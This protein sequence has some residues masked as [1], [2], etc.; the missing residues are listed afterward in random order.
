MSAEFGFT[1]IDATSQIPVQQHEMRQIV[2]K[3]IDLS[4]YLQREVSQG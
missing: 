2:S 3:A 4:Q 1:S